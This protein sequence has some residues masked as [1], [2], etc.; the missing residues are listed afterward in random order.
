MVPV[1]PLAE[2]PLEKT[3]RPVKVCAAF[4][5]A[6][7]PVRLTEPVVETS[8]SAAR[9]EATPVMLDVAS[10]EL[11]P[12]PLDAIVIVLPDW[13]MVM[14]EPLVMDTPPVIPLIPLTPLP[15][16]GMTPPVELPTNS[17]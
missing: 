9:N 6:T 1:N 17:L 8:K 11:P 14:L 10:G 3:C 2:R 4:V 16:K 12:P 5:L 7:V 15:K 13:V